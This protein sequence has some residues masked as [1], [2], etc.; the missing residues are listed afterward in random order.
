MNKKYNINV[1]DKGTFKPTGSIKT[2][3][4][5]VDNIIANISHNNT[6]KIVLFFHGGLVNE[7]NGV[8]A[9]E[10]MNRVIIESSCY[11]VSFVW[12]TGLGETIKERLLGIE[13]TRIFKKIIKYVLKKAGSKLKLSL[14]TKGFEALSDEEIEEE[15]EK[16]NPFSDFLE[17]TGARSQMVDRIDDEE[18]LQLELET[19]L[20]EDIE[21]DVEFKKDLK[22]IDLEYDFIDPSVVQVVDEEGQKGLI[23]SYKIIKAIAKISFMV[24]KRFIQ[25]RDHGFYPTVIEEIL[26]ELYIAGLGGWIWTGMKKKAGEMWLPNE[27]LSGEKMHTGTY[28]LDRLNTYAEN[29]NLRI[30]LIGH[31]A[32]SIAICNL[33]KTI[34][35]KFNNL[36]VNSVTFMAPA[37]R[38]DLFYKEVVS[39]SDRFNSFRMFT[40]TDEAESSD[41]LINNIPKLYPRSLLYFISGVLENNYDEYILGMHRFSWD[42][43][44]NQS[45]ILSEI[46]EFLSESD[47]LV[48]S[49]TNGNSSG[50]NS[51]ALDHGAF[52]EDIETINSIKYILTQV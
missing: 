6:D 38:S 11:P 42:S 36:R 29:K 31:S 45:Q 39:E 25:K 26:R 21:M 12:E 4:S 46:N 20:M 2:T 47:R 13:N 24:I 18:S 22:N 16:E 32:G 49:P 28:F 8:A 44:L 30:D 37:C 10:A 5:D 52:D 33:L 14:D 48:L 3:P 50:L 19:E 1:G 23:S 7:L 40:M 15:L 51:T 35:E 34:D 17:E 9:A 43:Y 41:A 27:G